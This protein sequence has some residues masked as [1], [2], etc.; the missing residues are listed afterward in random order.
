MFVLFPPLNK[1]SRQTSLNICL[2][3]RIL[4][5]KPID[6]AQNADMQNLYQ[7]VIQKK[8]KREL[9]ENRDSK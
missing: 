4:Y 5:K 9:R 3:K 2:K 1:K 7:V 6:F 8:E